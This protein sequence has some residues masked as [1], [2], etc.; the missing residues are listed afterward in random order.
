MYV[1][2]FLLYLEDNIEEI[3][4]F[5]DMGFMERLLLLNGGKNFFYRVFLINFK[6]LI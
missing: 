6:N 2:V 5:Y 1:I 3:Y 4:F